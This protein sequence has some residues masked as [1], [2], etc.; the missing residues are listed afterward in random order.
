[1]LTILIILGALIG[2]IASFVSTLLGGGAGLIATPAFFYIILHTYGA[3]FA[4]QIA[5]ATC[6]GMSD[7][8]MPGPPHTMVLIPA[9]ILDL[10]SDISVCGLI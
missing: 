10:I 2:F 7:L 6:C 1:M 3:D 5:L 8:P 9:R 4:M